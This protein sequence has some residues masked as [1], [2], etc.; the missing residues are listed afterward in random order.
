MAAMNVDEKKLTEQL[1]GTK[2][3]SKKMVDEYT[4]LVD[5]EEKLVMEFYA[6]S[7]SE[8]LDDNPLVQNHINTMK[9]MYKRLHDGIQLFQNPGLIKEVNKEG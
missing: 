3:I 1:R 9:Q 2:P 6:T 4:D 5:K 7:V 8:L